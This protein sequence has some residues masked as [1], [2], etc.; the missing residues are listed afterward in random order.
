MGTIIFILVLVVI[1]LAFMM[2]GED[3]VDKLVNFLFYFMLISLGTIFVGG[4]LCLLYKIL[5]AIFGQ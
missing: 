4:I 3:L 2:F 5:T 1:V